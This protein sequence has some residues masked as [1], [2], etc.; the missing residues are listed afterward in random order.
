MIL[1]GGNRAG[2]ETGQ[3]ETWIFD[4]KNNQWES[5]KLSVRQL[6]KYNLSYLGHGTREY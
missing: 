3:A 4:L 6:F 2:A 1:L 5:A